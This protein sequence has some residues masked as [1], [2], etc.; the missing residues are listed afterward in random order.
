MLRKIKKAVKVATLRY[1]E[2]ATIHVPV[3]MNDRSFYRSLSTE[4]K[5]FGLP[6][7]ICPPIYKHRRLWEVAAHLELGYFLSSQ[8]MY[9]YF[10]KHPHLF[11]VLKRLRALH[12][13][14]WQR[15]R[16]QLLHSCSI[17]KSY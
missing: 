10:G 13:E 5:A 17:R 15:S 8:R 6:G 11:F 14:K 1:I 3:L 9:E 2:K 7:D 16:Q 4:P 12:P